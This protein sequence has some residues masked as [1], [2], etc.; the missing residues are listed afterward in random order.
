MS[1]DTRLK[2]AAI[3]VDFEA[4]WDK[5]HHLAV[6]KL[7]PN[8]GGGKYEV[9]GINQRYNPAEC[10]NLIKLIGEKKYDAAYTYACEVIARD[11]DGAEKWHSDPGVQFYLRD[12][13][14]N[15]GLHGAAR[16]LQRA[17]GVKDDGIIGPMSRAAI[18]GLSASQLLTKLR[19]ARED[20]ERKVVGYRANFWKGLVN[21]WNNSLAAAKK[22]QA[23]SPAA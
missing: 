1:E 21:R 16:I 3:I 17:V 7:P 11:T 12:C 6:Y 20:Y 10:A 5:N 8:D 13:I 9:A 18:A 4:R 23:A 22:L 15:R 19:W 2:Q 14:F